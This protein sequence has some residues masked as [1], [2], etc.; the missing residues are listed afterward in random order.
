MD[1]LPSA[2]IAGF[3]AFAASVIITPAIRWCAVRYGFVAKPRNDRWHKRPTAM[4]GGIAIF[5]ATLIGY[6]I[7]VPKTQG[8]MVV[9]ASA[10]WLFIVGLIDDFLNIKP[11]Q[12]LFGQIIGAVVVIGFGMTI[13][14]TGNQIF[15]IWLTLFWIVGITNAINLLDN[16]DGLAAGIAAIASLSLAA[17]LASDGQISELLFVAVF[18]GSLIGFL[19]YNFNP[20]SIFMGDCGSMF[21]GFLL[22][23]SVL[24]SQSGGRS[25]GIL[26]ILA[27]PFLILFVPIFDTTFVTIIRKL[28]GKRAT[29]GGRD[30]TSHRLVALGLTERSAVLLLYGLAISA[31]LL[32]IAVR[33]LPTATSLS[34]IALFTA[35][36]TI[37]GVFLSKVRVY[38]ETDVESAVRDNAVFAFLLHFTHKRRVFEILLDAVLIT[39]SYYAAYDLLFGPLEDSPNRD[40]FLN[41]L[42]F[43]LVIKLFALLFAGV[44]R[45]I[46]RYTSISDLIVYA[47]GV[48]LGSL[49]SI[50]AVLLL[51]R[52]Q[53]FSRAVFILDGV[54]LFVAIV[55]SRLTFRILRELTPTPR[56]AG[57][58]PALIYGAGDGGEMVLRELR[59]N[60][61]WN[62]IPIG[63][64]DDD[65]LKREKTISGLCV[66]DANG[67]IE[68]ICRREGVCEIIV[69]S[70]K[71]PHQ[72]IREIR[73]ACG[74][75]RIVFQRAEMRIEPIDLE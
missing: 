42:P 24:L 35:A 1:L 29:Q 18:I 16:M 71:I 12:K 10:A 6:L 27:V 47:K 67:S 8:S 58:R 25:R 49:L 65:P 45:G 28:S 75:T 57:S 68:E 5:L 14:L 33:E 32:A 54:I 74:E 7:F 3:T 13:P 26:S 59:K 20:A 56:P 37:I 34:L 9:F 52:F 73:L 72:R 62:I 19:L 61:E 40:L 64:I 55:G 36:L 66:Y 23:A 46:W 53:Y 22:S 43:I 48:A 11:Y 41:T 70:K 2:L 21:V 63:F 44:Y 31:G 50:A 51:Y 30:H 4:L 17:G 69:S 39:V 60:P 38:D 15:D